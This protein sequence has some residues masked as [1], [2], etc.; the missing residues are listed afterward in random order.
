MKRNPSLQDNSVRNKRLVLFGAIIF[1]VV[2]IGLAV[3]LSLFLKNSGQSTTVTIGNYNDYIKNLPNS[4]R[5]KIESALYSVINMNT[6]G[7]TPNISDALI[8]QNSYEQTTKDGTFT[9]IFIVDIP[10]IRQSYKLTNY[11][12]P[13]EPGQ[14]SSYDYTILAT[15]L[16]KSDLIYGD[17]NCKDRLSV[18]NG[19]IKSDPIINLLPYKTNF[20]TVALRPGQ[21]QSEGDKIQLQLTIY[22]VPRLGIEATPEKF[23]QYKKEI[24]EWLRSNGLNSDDYEFIMST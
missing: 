21:T 6:D 7:D 23:E 11:Y 8:R 15:C 2:L 18:E 12:S 3:S 17:F 19:L 16:D 14:K 20:Y 24:S 4:E 5:A 10:S 1:I 9:S 13:P 22:T